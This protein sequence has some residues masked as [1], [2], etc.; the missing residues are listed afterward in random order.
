MLANEAIRLVLQQEPDHDSSQTNASPLRQRMN[1]D[2]RTRQLSPKTQD[3]YL[4]CTRSPVRWTGWRHLRIAVTFISRK[5]SPWRS[6]SI[7][8]MQLTVWPVSIPVN[9]KPV[10]SRGG[11]HP[12]RLSRLR[13]GSRSVLLNRRPAT[14]R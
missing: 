9:R 11:Q 4:R 6:V 10:F 7:A 5:Y 14:G 1:D 3:T 13:A 12:R 8:T 2:M